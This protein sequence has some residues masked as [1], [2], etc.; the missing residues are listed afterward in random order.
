VLLAIISPGLAK[1]I[2]HFEPCGT[3][4]SPQKWA[5]GAG[6]AAGRSTRGNQSNGLAV[7]HTVLV[8][9]FR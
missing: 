5:G 3:H 7:A 4:R 6:G 9:T 1:D 2:R 8:A